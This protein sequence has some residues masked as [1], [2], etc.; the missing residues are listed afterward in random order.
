MKTLNE[1]LSSTFHWTLAVILIVVLM[2]T[3]LGAIILHLVGN[4]VIGLLSILGVGTAAMAVKA[5]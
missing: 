4:A 1:H 2:E 5:I 3:G